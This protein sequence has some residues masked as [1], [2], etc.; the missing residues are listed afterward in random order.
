M[1]SKIAAARCH[2]IQLATRDKEISRFE[3][4]P[5]IGMAVQLALHIRGLPLVDYD[6]A[7]FVS[8]SLL[9]IPRLAFDR[10]INILAEVE[11]VRIGGGGVV[12]KTILPTVPYFDEMYE[13]LGAYL[14][15]GGLDEFEALTL[16]IADRLASS[17]HNTDALA[18]KI[19]ADRKAFNDSVEIGTKGG[20]LVSR[21]ARGKDVLLNP[22][23]FS[24]NAELFADHV[25]SV[26][27]KSVDKTLRQLRSAQGWP[28]QLIEATGEIAGSSVD[29]DGLRLLQRLAQ[30]GVVK[31]PSI[32]TS[33]AGT[34]V[35]LFTPTPAMT[36][37]SPLKREVYERALAI[38]S[39]VRQGQL[40]PNR[41]RIRSPGAV[42]YTLIRDLQ[43]SPTSDYGEQYQGL[44]HYRVA[45][46]EKLNNGFFQ[47]KIIDTPENREALAIAYHLV[48]GGSAPDLGVDREAVSAM[49]GSR[50]YVESLLSSKLL[51]EKE[52]VKLSSDDAFEIEQLI[53]GF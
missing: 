25:A 35:F 14:E 47:L 44:V 42:L 33:H 49:S 34:A 53:L 17:P 36:N 31:P 38:V 39:A 30:D 2:E 52:T 4:I 3:A 45:R 6:Q 10:I 12:P 46:L 21:R 29:K 11:F 19:G 1:D 40:L 8:A 15:Q 7:K 37:L 51:R 27:A 5:E 16:E 9:G 13:G 18:G 26:G 50:E 22:S 28:V 24:E 48:T 20:F 32:T 41:F 43:L 23:Y